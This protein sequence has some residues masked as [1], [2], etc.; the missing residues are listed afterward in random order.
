MKIC[1]LAALI[2][3]AFAL[4]ACQQPQTS[5]KPAEPAST[6]PAETTAASSP[7]QAAPA[8]AASEPEVAAADLPVIDAVLTH[9]PEAP[10]PVNR[11]HAARVKVKIEIQEKVMRMADG[12]EYKFWTFGGQVPGQMIRVREGDIVDV[13]FANRSDSTVPHN[14]DFHAAT[15]PGGG[16]E[17]SFT[18]PGHVSNFS[19]K[20]LQPGLYIY[21]CAT[22][23]VG[24]HIANGMYGLILVEPKEGLPPVDKEFYVVQGD[25]YTKGKYGEAGLQ[26]FDMEKAI[27]EQPDYVVFNGNVGS[28]AGD[29]AL[30]AKV[31]DKIRLFVGNGG[32]NLV[33][34]FHVIGEIF[35]TVYVE[36]GALKNYNVQ[37][38]LV[39]AG[40]AA[41]VD[42]KVDVPGTYNLVDH[43]IFRTFNKGAL[44]QIKVE[45]EENKDIFSGKLTEGIYHSEGGAIQTAPLTASETAKVAAGPATASS[46]EDRIKLG[47]T[48]YKAN[49]LAC[50]GVEGKGV[51]GAFPPLAESD[52]L[53]AD[54]KRGIHAV[55]KGLSGEITV[56][57]KKFNSVMPAV[58]LNDEDAA[59]VLTF[60]LNSFGNKG[61]EVKPEEIT[62][63]RK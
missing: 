60:V 48:V 16:A 31:G 6:K 45:G 33:S 43:S 56:N 38:T 3:S 47:E 32:P 2:A 4:T 42:F 61:G 30:K 22:A 25:F 19:F 11:N 58:A 41:I 54:Y 37:T 13:E 29:N 59:N 40:G 14:I 27:R 35:D 23:P 63:A 52:Y 1:T 53:N 17:A 36:G 49:C 51:E 8:Q 57:G 46:K 26:P 50:H 44:G 20:A 18:A 62:A 15:G 10:P 5:A 34:S 21:H 39:P 55:V 9:A 24:M 12:V 7:A 28:I